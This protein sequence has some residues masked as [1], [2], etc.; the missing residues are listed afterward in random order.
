MSVQDVYNFENVFEPACAKLLTT[1]GLTVFTAAGKTV[2]NPDGSFSIAAPDLQR[3]RPRVEIVFTK[4]S[5][6]GKLAIVSPGDD[7]DL[8]RQQ[9]WLGNFD[10]SCVTDIQTD[11][12]FQYVAEVRNL[13]ATLAYQMNAADGDGNKIYLPNHHMHHPCVE[14]GEQHRYDTKSKF[15]VTSIR[16]SF[17][18]S[19]LPSAWALLSTP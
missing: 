8:H 15:F 11:V 17:Q 6:S 10:F 19:I 18:F 5:S 4:G 9:A 14:S 1:R 12:H 7:Y 16:L 2:L 13:L 3:D